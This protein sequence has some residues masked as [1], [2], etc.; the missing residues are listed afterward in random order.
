MGLRLNQKAIP[1][2]LQNCTFSESAGLAAVAASISIPSSLISTF[3]AAGGSA[4]AS[5][6]WSD[7]H[8]HQH[9]EHWGRGG[10]DTQQRK[11]KRKYHGRLATTDCTIRRCRNRRQRTHSKGMQHISVPATSRAAHDSSSGV[12]PIVEAVAAAAAAAAAYRMR[13]TNAKIVMY[14]THTPPTRQKPDKYDI[15]NMAEAARRTHYD[16]LKAA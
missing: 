5:S 1:R 10:P 8:Q 2:L 7:Q 6:A 9:R 3:V 16:L 12:L 4:A 15:Y 14:C 13:Q 11:N